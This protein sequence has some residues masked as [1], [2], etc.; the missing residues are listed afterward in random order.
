[1]HICVGV[2]G[3]AV[4]GWLRGGCVES[5]ELETHLRYTGLEQKVWVT[6]IFQPRDLARLETT[7]KASWYL[8]LVGGV[9]DLASTFSYLYGGLGFYLVSN[10]RDAYLYS[11]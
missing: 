10:G 6:T 3:E 7:R 11:N 9:E 4:I 8:S 5:A 1:M 2:A